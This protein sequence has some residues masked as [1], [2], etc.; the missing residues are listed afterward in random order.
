MR[1]V[2]FQWTDGRKFLTTTTSIQFFSRPI[3]A[4]LFWKKKGIVISELKTKRKRFKVSQCFTFDLFSLTITFLLFDN[5][6]LTSSVW[7]LITGE[8]H[9][10][11]QEFTSGACGTFTKYCKRI[12]RFLKCADLNYIYINKLDKAYFFITQCILIVKIYLR[13]LFQT[14]NCNKS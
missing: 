4:C 5:F 8:I 7:I 2:T 3:P 1:Q 11:E 9:F 10:Q 13:K 12:Q 6:S 14:I